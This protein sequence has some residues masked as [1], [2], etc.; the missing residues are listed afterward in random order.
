MNWYILSIIPVLGVLV[1]VHELGHFIAAK[2]AGIR[3]E[4]FGMG[5]PP[6]LVSIRRR[7]RGGW[8]VLWFGQGR[9]HNDTDTQNPFSGVAG[10]PAPQVDMRD[11][12]RPANRATLYSLNLLPIGGFVRMPGETGDA[13]DEYGKYDP[14][15]FAAKSAGKRII[16]LCAGVFMNLVLAFVLFTIAYGVGQPM[17]SSAPVLGTV[18][19]NSPA[20]AAGLQPNDRIIS[21]NNQPVNTFDDMRKYVKDVIDADKSDK[22][23]VRVT[24]VIQHSGS[25]SQKTVY[26]DA[27]KHPANGQGAMGVGG[28]VTLVAT[29]LWQA[30]FKGIV[31]TYDMLHA[32]F[33]AMRDMIVGAI[34]PQIAGPVG[35]AKVTGDVA[36]LTPTYGWWP[37]LNLTAFLSLNLAIMNIL[38]FPA[39]D[40]GRVVLVL[41]ELLR[42]GKRLKPEREGL[43]NFI[44]IAILLLLMVVVTVSDV[45]HLGGG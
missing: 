15:S 31:Q 13:V 10:G 3:V 40:G 17:P 2:W 11:A 41:I 25:S 32:F 8:E 18:E 14:E 5:F 38:P 37:I 44:G 27:R 22:A 1:F 20:S 23:T 33:S 19:Q 7:E 45:M 28:Q 43:I 24:L 42:G 16:V 36:Q 35:I 39:L 34:Q 30:P 29:P 12:N 21:V 26:V 6:A 9:E 4:E